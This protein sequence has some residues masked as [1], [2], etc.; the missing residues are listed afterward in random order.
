VCLGAEA[1]VTDERQILALKQAWVRALETED[2]AA[3][4]RI[5]A[6][7]FTF[8]EPDGSLLTRD[9]YLTARAIIQPNVEKILERMYDFS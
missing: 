8:I 2:R 7:D 4:E 9:A 1:P 5:V 6:S 3:L